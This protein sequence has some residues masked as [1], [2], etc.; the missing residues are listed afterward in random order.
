MTLANGWPVLLLVPLAAWL[1]WEWGRSARKLGLLLKALAL[2]AVCLAL[3][4]PQWQILETYSAVAILN[5]ASASIPAEQRTLQAE[6][7]SAARAARSGHALRELE[8][9][10]IP[11]RRLREPDAGRSTNIEAAVTSAL[12][13]LPA[14]RVPR[15]V[16]LSDGLENEGAV[17]RAVYQAWRR[18]VPVDT[19]ALQGRSEPQLRVAGLRLP[20]QAFTGEQ[21]PIE[22]DVESPEAAEA[23]L[24]LRAEGRPIGSDTIR[25]SRGR[26]SVTAR[27]RIDSPGATLVEGILSGAGPGD[28]HFAGS[29]TIRTPRALLVSPDTPDHN[30]P[31]ANVA[32]AAGFE[33]DRAATPA[34]LAEAGGPE[35]DI[36]IG[37]QR[38]FR[39]L[40]GS[41]E[42]AAR[43]FREPGA[44]ASCSLPARGTS[45]GIARTVPRMLS[46]P[47]CRQRWR[48]R[49]PRRAPPSS[50]WWTSRPRW[51]ARRCTWP[52]SRP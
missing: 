37:S 30:A 42:G 2:A 43:L 25:L 18:K 12:S 21:F 27:A 3:S 6:W 52:A 19:V 48:R 33:L 5:D 46:K 14:D 20:R 50:W 29:V 49:G 10:T 51:K 16:L 22:F 40:A 32:L 4:R 24:E 11:L 28:L 34:M 31:L 23:R 9:G 7:A 45:T 44:E 8:F 17:E 36:V 15:L 38:G 39:S 1:A 47:C 35:Y 26:N 41:R 13:A